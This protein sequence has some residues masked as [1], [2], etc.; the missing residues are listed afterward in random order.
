MYLVPSGVVSL[1]RANV[2][3]HMSYQITAGQCATIAKSVSE[4]IR[5]ELVKL[6]GRWGESLC[7]ITSCANVVPDVNCTSLS[8]T[9]VNLVLG[10]VRYFTHTS[11][12]NEFPACP[13]RQ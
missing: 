4:K 12:V 8:S 11:V 9:S 1:A 13:Q 2:Y 5:Q 7:N 6:T 10:N 3:L